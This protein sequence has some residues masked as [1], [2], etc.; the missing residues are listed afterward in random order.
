MCDNNIVDTYSDS[1]GKKISKDEYEKS[2]AELER[3]ERRRLEW[4]QLEGGNMSKESYEKYVSS[5]PEWFAY[6][7]PNAEKL[8]KENDDLK[9]VICYLEKKIESLCQ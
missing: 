7:G 5:H 9:A 1:N 6:I 8:R 4:N 2:P 3:V